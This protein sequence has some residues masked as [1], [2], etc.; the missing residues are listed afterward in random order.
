ME[1]PQDEQAETKA[2]R[3]ERVVGT[4]KDGWQVLGLL[5]FCVVLALAGASGGNALAEKKALV[6]IFGVAGVVGLSMLVSAIYW[7]RE[8][9]TWAKT[10]F[11]RITK[12]AGR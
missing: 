8:L 7:R 9:F 11:K 5:A 4:R 3:W 10:Q 2:Q 12:A 1:T 6:V